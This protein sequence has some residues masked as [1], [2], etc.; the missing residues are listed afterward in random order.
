M[1]AVVFTGA[2]QWGVQDVPLPEPGPGRVRL[3]VLAAGMC[4]TDRHLLDGG[5][6]AR[7]PLVP[8]H[9]IVGEVEAFG[10]GVDDLAVGTQ[11][12][13]DNTELCG[14]CRAC[15][16]DQPLYC[17]DFGSLGVNQPGG[18]AE[19][20]V[21]RAEKCFPLDGL[22]PRVAVLTEPLACVVHGLDVLALRPGSDV[23]VLGAGP[24]GLLLAQ[25]L[26]ASGASRVTVAAPTASKLEL[27]RA[28]GADETVR[29]DRADPA[30]ALPA[31]RALAPD[32]FDAVVEATGSTGLLAL[33]PG[34]TATGG[35][36]LVYGMAGEDEVVP[37]SPYEIFSRELTVRGSFAQTHCFDRALLALRTGRVRADGIVTDVLPLNGFGQALEALSTSEKVKS[38][39]AP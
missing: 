5:F 28:L 14:R 8:G 29:L 21:V 12:A 31:L 10:E 7:F 4:G 18:F 23:L 22:D 36:V 35:T 34:L 9:E 20:V 27:A 3:R 25:L 19:A 6:L 24:T 2:G 38:V 33:C 30:A 17:A 15:R 11:V 26:H 39:L 1:Q 16:R 13:A 32:G 37:F